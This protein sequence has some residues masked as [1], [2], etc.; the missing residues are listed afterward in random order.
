MT[1]FSPFGNESDGA[2]NNAVMVCDL[3]GCRFVDYETDPNA[4]GRKIGAGDSC[5]PTSIG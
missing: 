1:G 3:V 2:G 5:T 4:G